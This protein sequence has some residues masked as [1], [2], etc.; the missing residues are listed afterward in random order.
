MKS[1]VY[2]S[3]EPAERSVI[4]SV[5]F[6]N[7]SFNKIEGFIDKE[8]FYNKNN[9]IVF[10]NI[11][12]MINEESFVDLVTLAEYMEKN[13]SLTT[14]GGPD[15]L[16]GI[17][18]D[19]PTAQAIIHHADILKEKSNQRKVIKHTQNIIDQWETIKPLELFTG[20]EDLMAKISEGKREKEIFYPQDL[21]RELRE[22]QETGGLL[23][24]V[25]TPWENMSRIYRIR[26]G[27]F[28]VITGSPGS[29]KSTLLDNIIVYL[30]GAEH[31]RTVIFSPENYPLGFHLSSFIEK[32]IGTPISSQYNGQMID[33]DME[34][35]LNFFN[36]HLVLL[37]PRITP[38]IEH[39]FSLVKTIMK[40]SKVDCL[41]IDPFNMIDN[42]K[43]NRMSETESIGIF[44]RKVREFARKHD[45]HIFVVAHPRKLLKKRDGNYEPAVA[46]DINGSAHWFNAADYILSVWRDLVNPENPTKVFLQKVRFR[47]L[48][49]TGCAKLKFD[50]VCGKYHD[51]FDPREDR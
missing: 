1:K 2:P 38:T 26:K 24:G 31:W 8:D 21:S 16:M 6:D 22:I 43:D 29:G 11:S 12:E 20:F 37:Q 3:N 7:S 30:T 9:K 41:V 40:K 45:I 51:F 28:T 36:D 42:P 47:Q 33:S 44:L 4:G 18:N 39:I 15:Y 25:D 49:K 13:G 27:L 34:K 50:P 10:D 48:G 14:I 35:A 19:V 23:S 32:Y 46:Y 5:L 17:L